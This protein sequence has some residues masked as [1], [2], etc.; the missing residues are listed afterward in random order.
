MQRLHHFFC[1]F[2]AA[3]T[4]LP[5]LWNCSAINSIPLNLCYMCAVK[6]LHLRDQTSGQQ[7]DPS[8]LCFLTIYLLQTGFLLQTLFR[9]YSWVHGMRKRVFSTSLAADLDQSFIYWESH[10][11]KSAS[12]LVLGGNGWSAA[13][14]RP[15]DLWPRHRNQKGLENILVCFSPSQNGCHTA[16]RVCKSTRKWRRIPCTSQGGLLAAKKC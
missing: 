16:R 1:C 10:L 2:L 8:W 7:F 11:I 5:P 6:T 9:L 12:F 14:A 4:D 15:N 3:I 13:A